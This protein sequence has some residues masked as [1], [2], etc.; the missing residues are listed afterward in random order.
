M[1]GAFPMLAAAARDEPPPLPVHFIFGLA[2]AADDRAFRFHHYVAVAAAARHL[3]PSPVILHHHHLPPPGLWWRRA[4][5]LLELRRVPLPRTI[6]GRPL[7]AAAHRADV[8]RLQLLI[9]QGGIYLDLDVVVLRPL[10]PLLRGGKAFVIGREGHSAHGG[11]HGLCNAVLLARPNASFARRWLEEYRDFG[12]PSRG[13]PW[14]E[15]SVQ[16]P[17]TLAAAHP[18]E[19][20]VLPYTAFFWPDWDERNLQSLLLQRTEPLTH[21]R[22]AVA[23]GERRAQMHAETR[24]ERRSERRGE[25]SAGGAHGG[26]RGNS[27]HLVAAAASAADEEAV[28]AEAEEA[29]EAEQ[30]ELPEGAEVA[31]DAPAYAVHLWSSLAARFVLAQWSPEYLTTVPATLNCLLQ[32]ALGPLPF[33]PPPLP[34]P[35]ERGCACV[36]WADGRTAAKR[37]VP[38]EWQLLAHWPLRPL[39][40]ASARLLADFSGHCHH[41]WAYSGCGGDGREGG[42]GE[43]DG[44]KGGEGGAAA[45]GRDGCWS[46]G[47]DARS[48]TDTASLS[49]SSTHLEAFAPMPRTLLSEGEWTVTWQ[50]RVRSRLDDCGGRVPFW[51]L[52]FAGGARLHAAAE[53]H[54]GILVPTLRWVARAPSPRLRWRLR[55]LLSNA[56]LVGH[57]RSVCD[58]GW[59]HYVVHASA[60]TRTLALFVDGGLVADVTWRASWAT[61]HDGEI[62]PP[63]EGVWMA[64]DAPDQIS[65]HA[66]MQ[67]VGPGNSTHAVLMADLALLSGTL[68]PDALPGTLR[69][70]LSSSGSS[71]SGSSEQRRAMDDW[72]LPSLHATHQILAVAGVALLALTAHAARRRAL[73]HR[74]TRRGARR[75]PPRDVEAAASAAREDASSKER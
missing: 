4:Q 30:V 64:G 19:V 49:V 17:I 61:E 43:G 51:S 57:G 60:H 63:L 18:D 21:L 9:E 59:H 5:L 15:H 20:R 72:S 69:P 55:A 39:R 52:H 2:D 50:V 36:A 6:F 29:E 56:Q 54:G 53:Q 38:H 13:D 35:L 32:T 22:A 66:P 71:S 31:E 14:S 25:R 7:A 37:R 33:A 34:A 12:D 3:R 70:P 65:G 41:G 45:T 40:G 23:I 73:R 10:A 58:G 1:L 42:D 27:S 24:G 26:Y 8:L 16:R 75:D 28:R 11:Y 48:A 68:A 74:S 44:R 46:E 67:S 47:E 62:V